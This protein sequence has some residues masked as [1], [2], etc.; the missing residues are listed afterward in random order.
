MRPAGAPGAAEGPTYLP[1]LDGLRA[2]AVGLVL[3]SHVPVEVPGY[4]DW[5]RLL[6]TV[7]GPGGLGVDIFFALSGFL[8]TR[9]LVVERDRGRPVRRFML[10]RVLR[11]FPI[12]YLLVV[13]MAVTRG[14][15][16]LPWCA[17]YLSNFWFIVQ[18]SGGPMQHTWS[19]CIEEH[20]YLL[21]PLAVA[22]LPPRLPPRLLVWLV[23]PAAVVGAAL[24]GRLAD[25]DRTMLIVQYGSP[26]RFL[27]LGAGALIAFAE[28]AIA[29]RPRAVAATVLV[30][31]AGVFVTSPLVVYYA[32][33]RWLGQAEPLLPVQESTVLWLVH[34]CLISTTLVL[35]CV[36]WG[37]RRWS[38]LR[39]LQA[40]PLRFV[41]RISY[42]L[43]LYHHPIY[44][45]VLLE[46]PTPARTL[47]ALGLSF[48]AATLSYLVLERPILRFGARFR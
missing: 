29:R 32:A 11:I 18:G 38:P 3:W 40:A 31:A 22:F 44:H 21:W 8:I 9:I 1:V 28:A 4:P 19:L 12:Y 17:L 25:P 35:S 41:G 14:G 47:L 20:F 5:L 13:I 24:V 30:L 36:A 45:A 26:F 46:S 2:L 48:A 23:L 33:P 39:L 7:V 15:P 34:V 27:S 37:R 43:Y 42:G 10:R 6:R 16:E